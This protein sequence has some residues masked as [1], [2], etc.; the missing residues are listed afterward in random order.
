[1]SPRIIVQSNIELDGHEFIGRVYDLSIVSMYF[2]SYD[3]ASKY[4]DCKYTIDVN[5]SLTSLVQRVRSINL[6]A[7]MLWLEPAVDQF[8]NLPIAEYD[9]LMV[10]QDVFLM[11]YVSVLDCAL[12]LANDVYELNQ[13]PKKCIKSRLIKL[14]LPQT[15]VDL[16]EK[17]ENGQEDLRNERNARFHHGSEKQMSSD[18][19]TFRMASLFAKRGS[20]LQGH[21]SNGEKIELSRYYNET[22]VVMRKD[23]NAAIEILQEDL[24]NLLNHFNDEFEIRFKPKFRDSKFPYK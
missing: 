6:S 9:W 13:A 16:L 1:M 14:G 23:F 5:E 17:I 11:R 22:A 7:D 24:D 4:A 8:S 3:E 20:G 15:A 12:I 2:E 21:D 18:D 10:A 19:T